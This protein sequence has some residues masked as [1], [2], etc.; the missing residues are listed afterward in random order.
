MINRIEE[1]AEA[2]LRE[3]VKE[4]T[5][6]Y[7][8][9][10]LA[11]QTDLRMSETLAKI[12]EGLPHAWLYPEAACARIFLDRHSYSSPNYRRGSHQQRA[13]IIIGGKRRGYIEVS[14]LD[15]RP[16][17][18]EGPFLKEERHLLEAV[19][20]EVSIII[21]HKEAE[22]LRERIQEQLRHAD[23]LATVG[24]LA[25]G[26]AHE[27][28]EPLGHIL[29]FAQLAQ[30]C[31]GLPEQA[32][33]DIG[34]VLSTSLYAREIV[35]KLLIFA[36]QIPPQKNKVNVNQIVEEVLSF[37]ESQCSTNNVEVVCELSPDVPEVN[38][39][40]SQLKQVF[41]NLIVNA[42]QAM[43][44][45]GGLA[46]STLRDNRKVLISVSDTGTGMDR[47]TLKNIF[48]PFFTTKPVGLGTGLGLPVVHG[49]I[50]SHQGALKI[51]S[52][53]GKGT[54]FT[55]ELPATKGKT[56]LKR[57]G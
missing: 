33:M 5:C 10:Q 9:A 8:I 46:I 26:V 35:K 23:R 17:R 53:V 22:Q 42:L 4:L 16:D 47:E 48:T 11:T 15:E 51:E 37:L 25:A 3:R 39:D 20:K 27:L 2:D 1:K 14:Y 55:V 32:Q 45:G 12:V 57:D 49:I 56:V 36:R 31:P 50:V 54:T 6:L 13:F 24:Q 34:K 40:P 41:V 38:A 19:A 21:M 43:P 44:N 30:K 29:G 52:K 18:D 28:N 7:N